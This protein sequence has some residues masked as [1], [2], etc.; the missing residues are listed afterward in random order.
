M[1]GRTGDRIGLLGLAPG[2]RSSLR[3]GFRRPRWRARAQRPLGS[4][5]SATALSAS[6]SSMPIRFCRSRPPKNAPSTRGQPPAQSPRG[7]PWSSSSCLRECS[8]SC[9]FV[10]HSGQLGGSACSTCEPLHTR[11]KQIESKSGLVA[12][13]ERP[14]VPPSPGLPSSEAA[15]AQ[16][17]TGGRPSAKETP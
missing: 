13:P 9:W 7:A 11:F 3:Q 1:L 15:T 5:R 12:E 4:R 8:L 10:W 14:G 16:G 2:R 17:A 6:S